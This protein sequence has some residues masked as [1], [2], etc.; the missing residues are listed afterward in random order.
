MRNRRW[1]VYGMAGP[2]CEP[3]Q[4][5]AIT[6]ENFRSEMDAF[7]YLIE[8]VTKYRHVSAVVVELYDTK[9]YSKKHLR[10][11]DKVSRRVIFRTKDT[12]KSW[13]E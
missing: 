13:W 11:I 1:V 2:G 9:V 12:A 4:Q 6:R 8:K 7:A 3:R 5:S 10:D